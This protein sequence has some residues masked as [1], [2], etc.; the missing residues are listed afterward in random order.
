MAAVS[1]GVPM[2]VLSRGVPM[3]VLSRG[4]PMVVVSHSAPFLFGRC[5]L[6]LPHFQETSLSQG[7]REMKSVAKCKMCQRVTTQQFT[8]G[9]TAVMSE[10]L[11]A[12]RHGKLV[13]DKDDADTTLPEV[14]ATPMCRP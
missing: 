6:A 11:G 14:F 5:N 9:M 10:V 8:T 13:R 1:R 3:V 12:Y 2:A 7:F 4:V